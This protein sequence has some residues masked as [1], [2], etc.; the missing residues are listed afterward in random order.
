MRKKSRPRKARVGEKG[1]VSKRGG[2]K[3]R[4]GVEGRVEEGS[5]RG[6]VGTE[7]KGV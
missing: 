1:G 7:G 2:E 5:G 6:R 4:E 3:M